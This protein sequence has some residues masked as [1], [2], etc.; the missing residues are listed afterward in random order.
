MAK[1]R[2]PCPICDLEIPKLF[3]LK[4]ENHNFC[5]SFCALSY[6]KK[7]IDELNISLAKWK[8]AWFENREIIGRI[9]NE[10]IIKPRYQKNFNNFEMIIDAKR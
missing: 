3:K 5:S 10:F 7:R 4:I 6:S 1:K 8:D 2:N 9:G